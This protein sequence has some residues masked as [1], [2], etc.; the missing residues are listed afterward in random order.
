MCM[1]KTTYLLPPPRPKKKANKNPIKVKNRHTYTHNR[2]TGSGNLQ[3]FTA[4]VNLSVD[5]T[6]HFGP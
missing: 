1:V 5:L 6:L 3:F 4:M 2:T